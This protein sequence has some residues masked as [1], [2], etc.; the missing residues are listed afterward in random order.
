MAAYVVQALYTSANAL[1]H[2]QSLANLFNA[3]GTSK[4]N[5]VGAAMALRNYGRRWDELA[6]RRAAIR[7]F[8]LERAEEARS[9]F[10]AA[11]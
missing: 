6:E 11:G 3:V 9:L 7:P 8:L 2:D 10:S 4:P 5:D 1:T